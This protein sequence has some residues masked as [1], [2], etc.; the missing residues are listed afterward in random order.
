MTLDSLAVDILLSIF[1]LTD[2]S[3]V[4]SLSQVNR[5]FYAVVN[6]K[7]LWLSIV[8]DLAARGLIDAAPDD[9][10]REFSTHA[11]IGEIRR[12]VV[13]PHTW[14]KV[15]ID[16]PTLARKITLPIKHWDRYRFDDTQ[17]LCG[18]KY[19]ILTNSDQLIEWWDVYAGRRVWARPK[20]EGIYLARYL[21][22]FR[23]SWAIFCPELESFAGRLF[24]ISRVDVE[25]G[26]SFDILRASTRMSARQISGDFIAC[27]MH[28]GDHMDDIVLVNW[29]L[30]EFVQLRGLTEKSI[31]AL[32]RGHIAFF[33]EGPGG[34]VY[35]FPFSSF[36]GL[37]RPCSGF[38]LDVASINVA[39]LASQHLSLDIMVDSTSEGECRGM[40][41]VKSPLWED[42]YELVVTIRE[43]QPA[44]TPLPDL[45]NHLATDIMLL[46]LPG[47]IPLRTLVMGFAFNFGIFMLKQLTHQI[48]TR[49]KSQ[50]PISNEPSREK[51]VAYHYRLTIPPEASVPVLT[52]KSI[53]DPEPRILLEFTPAG[54][55]VHRSTILFIPKDGGK[56]SFR[57]EIP[58]SS[59]P[60][61]EKP[62]EATVTPSNAV[63]AWYSDRV[64][65]CYYL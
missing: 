9:I 50:P 2:I 37:W 23:G 35:L 24:Q 12:V 43:T 36:S 25:T 54:Y 28:E 47:Y 58:N 40:E 6:T 15:S 62:L 52:F 11:L 7:H 55:Y 29:R 42:S 26:Q 39:T 46:I 34:E 59:W 51:D 61:E 18:G 19:L 41:I 65:V 17:L 63:L 33:A 4:L 20:K 10:L 38:N 1:A 22:H 21:L 53:S 64:V 13:G 27:K 56:T 30:E 8:R 49:R 16:P 57:R 48:F 3:T 14:S 44:S 31:F 45:L 32:C 60:N 5:A